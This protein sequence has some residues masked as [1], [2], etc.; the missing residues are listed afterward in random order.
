MSYYFLIVLF[1]FKPHGWT[2]CSFCFTL[3]VNLFMICFARGVNQPSVAYKWES[4][5]INWNWNIIACI[6]CTITCNIYQCVGSRPTSCVFKTIEKPRI[7]PSR[8]AGTDVLLEYKNRRWACLLHLWC[9]PEVSSSSDVIYEC[10]LLPGSP[11]A[12]ADARV[13]SSPPL[14][15][16]SARL[17]LPQP[18]RF[19]PSERPT[20]KA[21]LIHVHPRREKWSWEKALIWVTLLHWSSGSSFSCHGLRV[22]DCKPGH[23]QWA[24]WRL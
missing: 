14:Y 6:S 4:Q 8:L 15:L 16:S 10:F 24:S 11:V 22:C 1:Y 18:H 12:V 19:T 3:S 13:P 9:R 21:T 7:N 5:G 20:S 23:E 17:S 2:T